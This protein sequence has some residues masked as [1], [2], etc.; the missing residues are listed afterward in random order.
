MREVITAYLMTQA[1]TAGDE[2][3]QAL[4]EVLLSMYEQG[5]ITAEEM[6]SNGEPLF[7]LVTEKNPI[8][9]AV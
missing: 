8:G 9:F 6:D 2:D 1:I 4:A 3:Q 5:V 7:S